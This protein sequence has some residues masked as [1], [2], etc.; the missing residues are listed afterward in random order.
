MSNPPF[1]PLESKLKLSLQIH[2]IF[3]VV[4][5]N[6][7]LGAPDALEETVTLSKAVHGVIGLAHGADETA[8]GI[9]VVLAGDGT[10]VLVN[11][12]DADLD[13]A[14]VLG[15][16]DAVGGRALSGDVATSNS[17]LVLACTINE[18]AL[19]KIDG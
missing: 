10:A 6:L 3:F 15:L 1:A 12:G 19:T 17:A 9:D 13:G 4:V 14:V 7:S 11:L 18:E 2:F 8:E 16:D 5:R